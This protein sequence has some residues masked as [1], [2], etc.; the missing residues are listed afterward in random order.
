MIN[1][2]FGVISGIISSLGIGGGTVLI[3]LL[4]S[5]S[6]I[7]QHIA[8][9]VNLIFFI[10]T[11]IVSIF[12]NLKNNNIEKRTALIV[13]IFGIIGAIL[14]A[15]IAVSIDVKNLKK[16][17]GLFL[18]IIAFYEIFSLIKFWKKGHNKVK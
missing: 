13:S 14:G 17:F 4:I 9:G 7:E 2:I 1:I 5:F 18:L 15:R 3:F 10:P 6:E 11:S 16:Y 8:Q 12:I